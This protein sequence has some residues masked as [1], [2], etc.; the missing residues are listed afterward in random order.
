MFSVTIIWLFVQLTVN[1]EATAEKTHSHAEVKTRL[2]EN[3]IR[4]V[5]TL[6]EKMQ[7]DI[8]TEAARDKKETDSFLC[9]C[10]KHGV[11]LSHN[12]EDTSAKIPPILSE[13][14]HAKEDMS[15]IQKD[16]LK[17]Q[18]KHA[19]IEDTIVKATAIHEADQRKFDKERLT[20]EGYIRAL[21][22]AIPALQMH[23]EVSFLQ[24]SDAGVLQ[25]L[26]TKVDSV[27]M[28]DQDRDLL[29]SFLVRDEDYDPNTSSAQVAGIL[30]HMKSEIEKELRQL[31]MENAGRIASHQSIV[32]EARRRQEVLDKE[33]EKHFMLLG[34]DAVKKVS[35]QVEA[36]DAEEHIV[37]DKTSLRD[38]EKRCIQTKRDFRDNM[39]SRAKELVMITQTVSLLSQDDSLGLFKKSLK[40]ASASF[41]QTSS[42]HQLRQKVK[43]R[44]KALHALR[45]ARGRGSLRHYDPRLD[46]LAIA[47]RGGKKG[48]DSIIKMISDLMDTMH[49]EQ[50]DDDTKNR[51]CKTE[52]KMAGVDK[53]INT[54][55]IS[56]YK[57]MI[58]EKEALVEHLKE[59]RDGAAENIEKLDVFVD[60]E[61]KMRKE[62][63]ELFVENIA[64]NL[65]A[66]KILEMAE[67]HLTKFYHSAFV[68]TQSSQASFLQL[69]AH[70]KTQQKQSLLPAHQNVMQ[71]I[72]S[73]IS[74]LRKAEK[75]FKHEELDEQTD[76]DNF[77]KDSS[78]EK[79]QGMKEVSDH[80][81]ALA[82]AESD[83]QVFGKELKQLETKGG[84]LDDYLY[85]LDKQ[86]GMLRKYYVSRKNARANE[87]D[88]LEQAKNLLRS[89]E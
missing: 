1:V 70:A 48:F 77:M 36:G 72:G 14:D 25:K 37:I 29:T 67:E 59:E 73:L 85:D 53:D 51:W 57:M 8:K 82:T 34:E 30:K 41:I 9:Y 35:L 2:H 12:I 61:T 44:R 83:L 79:K 31:N 68:E 49:Q 81:T 19:D 26:S 21:G 17:V 40:S 54:K 28:T 47:M 39:E 69:H 6:L 64:N 33:I 4:K 65:A 76:Y 80:E 32:A 23:H 42:S 88:A 22:R 56:K 78:R 71:M 13:I 20:L 63:H 74:E 24:A 10:E 58:A 3:P 11:V 7:A 86:C 66:R 89:D 52:T 46:L 18:Q 60:K 84:K 50:I 15:S 87:M 62:E 27:E 75:N 16:L 38:L 43:A 5:V 45:K 55:D